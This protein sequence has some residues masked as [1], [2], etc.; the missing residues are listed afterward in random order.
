MSRGTGHMVAGRLDEALRTVEEA[1][2]AYLKT[3]SRKSLAEYHG[4]LAE[5][6]WQ[7]RPA[8]RRPRARS[9]RPW[10]SPTG[11]TA[12]ATRPSCTGSRGEVLLARSPDDQAEAEA[13]FQRSLEVAR[14]QSARSW[15][16]RAAMSLGKLRHGRGDR[17]G[18]TQLLARVIERF[19]QGF[20]TPDLRDARALL[21][22]WSAE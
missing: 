1:L 6:H 22:G 3:G 14:R 2:A 8:R 7:G 12:G 4:F 11:P 13:C 18:A 9:T 16:L 10:P 17:A 15:E 5:I 19:T 20:E 21:Q